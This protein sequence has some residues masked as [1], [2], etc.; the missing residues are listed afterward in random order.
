M[1]HCIM[2]LILLGK[3][4]QISRVKNLLKYKD[5]LQSQIIEFGNHTIDIML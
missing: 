3:Y 4:I 1:G 2:S 5:L